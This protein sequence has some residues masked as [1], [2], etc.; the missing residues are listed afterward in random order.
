MKANS[1]NG[2][3]YFCTFADSTLYRSR[4]RIIKQ[5][6]NFKLF[7]FIKFYDESDLDPLFTQK[8]KHQLNKEVRGYGYWIW[9]P[10][11]L[12]SLIKEINYGD[13]IFY[14]DVGCWLNPHGIDRFYDYL[15]IVRKSESGILAFSIKEDDGAFNLYSFPEYQWTKADLFNF[16]EVENQADI[17]ES[18]QIMATCF[19]I[20]KTKENEKFINDWMSVFE[21]DISLVDDSPSKVKNHDGFIEHRHDQSVFSLL[22]KRRRV[23]TISYC[24]I[25]YPELKRGRIVPNWLKL[26]KMPILAKRDKDA[27]FFAKCYKAIKFLFA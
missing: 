6:A 21:F 2:S 5:A 1:S 3:L 26:K 22:A 10:Y 19:F 4:K 9:K 14:A 24:E 25:F 15:D 8:Y 18:Q 11:I 27:G 16:F 7:D 12:K 23:D 13:V 17:V 20:K